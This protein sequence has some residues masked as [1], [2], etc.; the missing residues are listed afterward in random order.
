MSLL[1]S[2][3]NPHLYGG[4][5]AKKA[6]SFL[7]AKAAAEGAPAPTKT[8]VTD[9]LRNSRRAIY[10][11]KTEEDL[12]LNS[13]ALHE[14]NIYYWEFREDE[15]ENTIHFTMAISSPTLQNAFKQYGDKVFG[16]DAVWKY[17]EHRIPVWLVTVNTPLGVLPVG[18][19]ISTDG[20]GDH[21]ADALQSLIPEGI[22]PVAMIDHDATEK[23][24]LSKLDVSTRENGY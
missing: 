20:D 3:G 14:E 10:K 17:T 12:L 8:Q 13:K 9:Y 4:T 5:T 19:I 24:A 1:D 15:K 16:L 6:Y 23:Y 21:L 11:G 18:Y 2:A 7:S 22:K